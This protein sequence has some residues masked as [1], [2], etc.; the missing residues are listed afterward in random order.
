M[1][2]WMVKNLT[3]LGIQFDGMCM[4]QVW[5]SHGVSIMVMWNTPRLIK[6]QVGLLWKFQHWAVQYAISHT[7][8]VYYL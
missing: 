2:I 8:N 7:I 3:V 6:H 4:V 5:F 1:L